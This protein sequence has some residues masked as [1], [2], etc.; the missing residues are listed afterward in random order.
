M[1]SA[2]VIHPANPREKANFLSKL[3]FIWTIP[4][5][6]KSFSRI[7]QIEDIYEPLPEDRSQKLGDRLEV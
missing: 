4:I 3:F 6:R 1:E 7:L 2:R 5:F